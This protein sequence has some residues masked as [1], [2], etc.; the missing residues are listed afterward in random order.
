MEERSKYDWVPKQ[1]K[2][3][4]CSVDTRNAGYGPQGYK[5]KNKKRT[6]DM[7]REQEEAPQSMEEDEPRPTAPDVSHKRQ[8]VEEGHPYRTVRICFTI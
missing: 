6:L 5:E 7:L 3:V 1:E 8:K 2:V 4:L